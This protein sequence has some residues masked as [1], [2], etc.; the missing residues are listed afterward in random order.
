M[1][2]LGAR[3]VSSFGYANPAHLGPEAT[4]D[5]LGF[6]IPRPDRRRYGDAQAAR[7]AAAAEQMEVWA[8][9]VEACPGPTI[10]ASAISKA[11]QLAMGG[12]PM[13]YRAQVYLRVSGAEAAMVARPGEFLR[14]AVALPNETTACAIKAMED[15]EKDLSRT[16]T[17]HPDFRGD[18]WITDAQRRI[19]FALAMYAPE[20][21]YVQGMNFLAGMLIL[22]CRVSKDKC[23]L[24]T[25]R[26]V[27]EAQNAIEERA[28]WLL[29]RLV[30]YILP[31][32]FLGQTED[33]NLAPMQGVHTALAEVEQ[34]VKSANAA[35]V[36]QLETADLSVSDIV[37]HWL[38]PLFVGKLPTETT[39]RIWDLLFTTGDSVICTAAAALLSIQADALMEK[40]SFSARL[41]GRGD[42][43]G[44]SVLNE[45]PASLFEADKLID[46]IIAT[47]TS[48]PPSIVRLS[49]SLSSAQNG[50]LSEEAAPV[51]VPDANRS[52]WFS[53]STA[54]SEVRTQGQNML[55]RAGSEAVTSLPS[56]GL[57]QSTTRD[58][59]QGYNYFSLVGGLPTGLNFGHFGSTGP[60]VQRVRDRPE[61]IP[62]PKPSAPSRRSEEDRR[63]SRGNSTWLGGWLG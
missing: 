28:F 46:R 52:S 59:Q 50:N 7:R 44:L 11:R 56:M 1:I 49:P 61:P 3:A 37:L 30:L 42:S 20:V 55:F 36:D 9:W 19:L 23:D 26:G 4:V 8:T 16:F 57:S 54:A 39:L 29:V 15:I 21:G 25:S 35:F 2:T 6:Q 62:S 60:P 40:P 45:I 22:L 5:A 27:Q 18:S 32:A 58:V 10:N 63:R 31:P 51:R 14:L 41:T 12:I 34:L 24:E 47:S 13:Q 48:S 43:D 17:S 53:P 38:P 33:G